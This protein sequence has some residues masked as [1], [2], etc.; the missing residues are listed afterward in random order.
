MKP[1]QLISQDLFDK[2]RS[3][4]TN[5]EM[6]DE[7]GAV[8][9]DPAEARFF[10]FDFVNEG[11]DLGRV[12]IS[13]NDLGSLKIYYSQGITENQDDNGTQM[14][15]NFLKE[16]RL[17]AMRRL[18]RFDTR[19]IAKTNLDKNDF[20]HLAATQGPKEE[21]D[22]NTMN[23]NKKT[24][25]GRLE[26]TI[27]ENDGLNKFRQRVQSQGFTDSPEERNADRLERKRRDNEKLDKMH[28]DFMNRSRLGGG[29]NSGNSGPSD[30]DKARDQHQIDVLAHRLERMKRDDDEYERTADV[31]R[32][33]L[34]RMQYANQR[35][36][37]PEQL[38]AISNIK[39]EP[40]KK[41]T[42][43]KVGENEI[44]AAPSVDAKGRTAQEWVKLV[45][46]KYPD[47]KIMQSKMPNGPWEAKLSDGRTTYWEP[48]EQGVTR[49]EHT[50]NETK[51]IKKSVAEN[52]GREMTNTPRDRLISRMSP[53]VDNNALLQK[54]GKVV[55]SPE[56]NSDAILKI[57]DA[58]DTMTHPVGRYIQKEF[59][60]L[61]YDLGRAYEDHP[62]EVAEK[63]L[64]MLID[65]TQQGVA[66]GSG[67][68]Q[69]TPGMKTQYGTVVKVN[70][71]TVTV[72]ASN[73]ELTT[74]NI[75]DIQQG[76]AEGEHT[77]N[78]SRWNHK[79]SSKTSRAVRGKTEVVVRHVKKVAETYPG[80]RS[81]NKNIKAIFIQNADGE[82][83]KYP[84]I[85]LAGAFAMAQHVDHG[86]VP[87]DP[88]GKAIIK[89]SENISKLGEFQRHIQLSS[90]N[91]DAHGIAERA[92][93]HMN[94]LKAKIAALGKRHHY[95]AWREDFEM[96][97]MGDNTDEMV[98]DAVTLEDYKSKFTQ[99][100]FQEEL[101]GFF[102]LLHSIMRETNT[103][104]LEEY[105]SEQG[106]VEG[107]HEDDVARL[108]ADNEKMAGK[109]PP[110]E[111][112]LREVGNWA[113]VGHYGDPIKTAW[114]NIAKY[115]VRNNRFKD[116]VDQ[117][118]SAIGEFPDLEDEVY[119]MYDINQDEVDILYNAYETVYNQW[120]Q[121]QG[122]QGV[123]EVTALQSLGGNPRFRQN[124]PMPPQPAIPKEKSAAESIDTFE[125]WAD[126]KE[127][128][129]LTSD[130]M[131]NLKT[132]IEAL[133][134]GPQGPQLDAA[135]AND[136]FND[137]EK[138]LTELPNFEELTQALQ[139][140]EVRDEEIR[141]TPLQLFQSWAK[142]Y[143]SDLLA[144]L[145]MTGGE[146]PVPAPEAP[147]APAAPP[148]PEQPV[149]EGKSSMV[150]EVAKIVKS[151]YN[152]DNESV[153]P[154][155]AEENI[156]LDCKKQV[157]E[158][159][160]EKAGE[161]AYEMAEAFINKLTQEWQQKHGKI[162]KHSPVDQGD[163]FSVDGLKEILGRIK[164]KVEGIGQPEMEE[165]SKQDFRTHGMDSKPSKENPAGNPPPTDWK[166]D[167]IAAATDRAHDAGS[168]LLQRL[169]GIRKK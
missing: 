111:L 147:P 18:L 167:P 47:A 6:G 108:A 91:A 119:D 128:G 156:A 139:D 130:Q 124:L 57:V 48:A 28:A 24:K 1:I 94:E 102:P 31:L 136:F 149:A 93:G 142:E 71:N 168:K 83:A 35:N 127:K 99:T 135:I 82:R 11:V 141:A 114:L 26:G 58:G 129:G 152:A 154:F 137:P 73:G 163:G 123:A 30:L 61:Q 15:Y 32:D 101:V 4:F 126:A 162:Q 118:M 97:G 96:S 50:M 80:A 165:G 45:K 138:G 37:D 79:S 25:N 106:V 116:S 146:E 72:K 51:K 150:Q 95:E 39:Y 120:E 122:Q 55:N 92:I 59:D 112:G 41:T 158:K 160:G 132:A 88:A 60:E 13:L 103:V 34:N 5:L 151:F 38:A 153:G 52:T 9:I 20:Q 84:F 62:E 53:S 33:R 17:F 21:P 161:Q 12:S 7:T 14:W 42:D 89:M 164:Q 49:D 70:G 43:Y 109:N 90:I 145:G 64:A 87:H 85:H 125:E 44:P 68:S 155:R 36:V 110:I 77:M 69:I 100:N 3:R 46:A 66:E 86:G 2:V 140:E 144:A 159:F 54:V 76:V 67:D 8:T 143:N 121:L 29:T 78:E 104:D 134:Q 117:V 27:N 74:M 10:D 81:Q 75:H 23:E 113:K 40:R 115:G 22:M 131:N 133:P 98:L 148:A 107:S 157:T 16:M 166:T 19:D 169:A 65:R 105:V 56:F 63:L